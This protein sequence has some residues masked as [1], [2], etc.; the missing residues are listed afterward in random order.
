M[1]GLAV[2]ALVEAMAYLAGYMSGRW[3]SLRSR[4]V[5]LSS[6]V[7]AHDAELSALRADL[8]RLGGRDA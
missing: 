8:S 1:L 6:V 4:W 3:L 5:E 7:D 2:F